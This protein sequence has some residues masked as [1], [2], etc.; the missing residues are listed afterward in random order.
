MRRRRFA[1]PGG[2]FFPSISYFPLA[3]VLPPLLAP[4]SV[5]ATTPHCSHSLPPVLQE[6]TAAGCRSTSRGPSALLSS[7]AARRDGQVQQNPTSFS[8][9]LLRRCVQDVRSCCLLSLI[10]DQIGKNI[11]FVLARDLSLFE[12]GRALLSFFENVS[13]SLRIVVFWQEKPKLSAILTLWFSLVVF[14]N[15]W[16]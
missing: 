14:W 8:S 15:F 11:I 10:V 6:V 5:A 12:K 3:T 2:L 4:T 16:F 1:M 13:H 7:R 9:L